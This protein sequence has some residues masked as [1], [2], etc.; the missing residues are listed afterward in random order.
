MRD[1]LFFH[2]R[3][4][5]DENVRDHTYCVK[6]RDCTFYVGYATTHEKDMYCKKRGRELAEK[7]ADILM[8]SIPSTC[9]KDI[10][11]TGFSLPFTIDSTLDRILD[12]SCEILKVINKDSIGIKT[13]VSSGDNKVPVFI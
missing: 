3:N 9:F 2:E 12:K 1:T 7:K 5:V 11:A 10:S 13:F 8:N 4:H 6:L